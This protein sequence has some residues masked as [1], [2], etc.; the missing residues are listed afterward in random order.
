MTKQEIAIL[1]K[2]LGKNIKKIREGKGMS[3]LD[4]SYNCDLD[5]SRISK[6]EQGKVNPTMATL[7]ELAK[8]LEVDALTL[9]KGLD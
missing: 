3:L 4:V 6:I 2:K 9:L 5:D 1:K 7:F 8:G